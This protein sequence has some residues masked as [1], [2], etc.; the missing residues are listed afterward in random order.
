MEFLFHKMDSHGR[1][2]VTIQD[3]ENNFNDEAVIAFFES[4]EISAM[5]AW[6]LFLTLDIDG[7]HTVG[8]GLWWARARVQMLSSLHLCFFIELFADT[9]QMVAVH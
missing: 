3:F 4:M 5:D 8:V 9:G 1:G 6:T 2:K 7:D